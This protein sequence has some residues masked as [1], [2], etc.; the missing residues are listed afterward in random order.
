MRIVVTGIVYFGIPFEREGVLQ[1]V[2]GISP[3]SVRDLPD[4]KNKT[5][6]D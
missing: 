3:T 5:K 6:G 1:Y 2:R 4:G